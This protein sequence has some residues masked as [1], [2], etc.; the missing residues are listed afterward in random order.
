MK[1]VELIPESG[2]ALLRTLLGTRI[3]HFYTRRI[4]LHPGYAISNDFSIPAPD[5]SYVLIES[6]W[7]DTSIDYIDFHFIE[8]SKRAWP[9]G[10]PHIE[11]ES[12]SFH[13]ADVCTVH[14]ATPV[15]HLKK[16]EI[17]D[18]KASGS[19]DSVHFDQT[20]LFECE[21]SYRFMITAHE[22]I[23]GGLE[24]S[25]EEQYIDATID[26]TDLRVSID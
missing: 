18:S 17:R 13:L 11:N 10:T 16:I 5:G 12:G 20:I 4:D 26:K 19:T 23:R 22:S 25:D 6:D 9:K 15:T 1:H 24:Y 8:I 7:A 2:I 3:S 21:S 14:T